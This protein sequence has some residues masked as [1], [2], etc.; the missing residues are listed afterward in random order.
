MHNIKP[1]ANNLLSIRNSAGAIMN[2]NHRLDLEHP[3][4]EVIDG[5]LVR[6]WT[7]TTEIQRALCAPEAVRGYKKDALDHFDRLFEIYC[8]SG[9]DPDVE[10]MAAIAACAEN[11]AA[12]IRAYIDVETLAEGL[13]QQ[14]VAA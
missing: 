7:T 1:I 12:R 13:R 6:I 3:V 14:Q 9:V 5:Q 11:L 10:Q 4:R 2:A 8:A